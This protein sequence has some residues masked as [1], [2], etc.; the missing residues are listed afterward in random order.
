M[1]L[2]E[3]SAPNCEHRLTSVV[4]FIEHKKNRVMDNY[5]NNIPKGG[6]LVFGIFMILVYLAV[7][8]LCIF[9]VFNIDNKVIS[10]IVGGILIAYGVF[11]GYRLYRGY[12]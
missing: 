1:R 8:L 5:N 9:D 7:G 3:V 6:R 11:R 12:N 2:V 10:C 4:N